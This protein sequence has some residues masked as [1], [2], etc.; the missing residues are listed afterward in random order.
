[1]V[2]ACCGVTITGDLDTI[3]AIDGNRRGGLQTPSIGRHVAG[4]RHREGLVGGF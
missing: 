4:E 3:A 1:M 2:A